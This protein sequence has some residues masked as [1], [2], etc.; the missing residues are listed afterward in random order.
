MISTWRLKL[1]SSGSVHLLAATEGH[2]AMTLGVAALAAEA[3]LP[4]SSHLAANSSLA[5]SAAELA[6]LGAAHT[7]TVGSLSRSSQSAGHY[8]IV[9]EKNLVSIVD[10]QR[11]SPNNRSHGFVGFDLSSSTSIR[12]G[13]IQT[14][15]RN[16]NLFLFGDHPRHA[17][18]Y[19]SCA[20]FFRR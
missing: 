5:N 1:S 16:R 9:R 2:A 15:V 8:R 17:T 4:T 3:A 14:Q 18:G 13:G 12:S 20:P 6:A 7:A 11:A 10:S 19:I